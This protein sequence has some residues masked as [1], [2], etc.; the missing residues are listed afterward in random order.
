MGIFRRLGRLWRGFISLFVSGVEAQN[1]R[2]LLEAEIQDFNKARASFNENLAKQGGL[3]NRLKA[4]IDEEQKKLIILTQRVKALMQAQQMDKAQ[5]LALQRKETQALIAQNTEQLE[6]AE[7]LFQQLTRQRDTFVKQARVRIEKVKGKISAAEMAEAQA[8]LT[9]LASDAVFNPDGQGLANLDE[10]LTERISN[11]QGKVRVATEAVQND[12]W[13]VTEQESKALEQAALA[14]FASE[15]GMAA[16][17]IDAKFVETPLLEAG[18]EERVELGVPTP[19][20]VGV[21]SM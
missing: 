16:P 19:Q 1:P 15:M 13:V 3:I 8:K 10:K 14:E 2:A 17:P 12:A 18:E 7:S 9:E 21:K 6:A 11:A 20:K 4:Q 5:T